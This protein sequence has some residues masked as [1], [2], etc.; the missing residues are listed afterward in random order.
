MRLA[1]LRRACFGSDEFVQP[2]WGE[3]EGCAGGDL[4]SGGVTAE[5]VTEINRGGDHKSFWAC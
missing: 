5:S 2:A 4:G 1:R 3:S